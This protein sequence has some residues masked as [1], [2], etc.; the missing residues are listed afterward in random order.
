MASLPGIRGWPMREDNDGLG[1]IRDE[2][3]GMRRALDE[4]KQATSA[5]EYKF[6][7]HILN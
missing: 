6:D 4:I 5:G 3:N 2:L 1:E 7:S